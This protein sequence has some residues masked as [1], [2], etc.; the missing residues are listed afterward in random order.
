MADT[1]QNGWVSV[2]AV[3][4]LVVGLYMYADFRKQSKY[5]TYTTRYNSASGLQ[6]S[7]P[8]MIKGVKIGKIKSAEISG[9]EVIVVLQVNKD[10][11]LP[12]DTRA[13]LTSGGLLSDMSII[14]MP[15]SS[16]AMLAD[17]ANI[18]SILDTSVLPISVR[19]TPYIEAAKYLLRTSDSTMRDLDLLSST[20]LFT[21]ITKPILSAERSMKGYE[22]T[23]ASLD[24][25][26][27]GIGSK[28]RSFDTSMASLA[29]KSNGWKNSF[30]K[31]DKSAASLAKD[32]F[33]KT[34]NQVA[35]LTKSLSGVA[36]AASGSTAI[37]KLVNDK[38]AYQHTTTSLDTLNRDLAGLQQSPPGFH[39]FGKSKKK[40]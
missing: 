4:V 37:G 2:I 31:A 35:S 17:D 21:A 18:P 9:S 1:K 33:R 23:S 24:H 29:H 30:T 19:V 26:L 15:G 7:S 34:F 36:K 25:Q 10:I 16:K 39:I 14:L 20:G 13:K 22:N 40:K 28:L 6:P 12:V 38:T 11:L 8:V 27:A 5:N 3:I 32:S